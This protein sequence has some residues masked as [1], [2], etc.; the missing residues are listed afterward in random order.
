MIKVM[1]S[2]ADDRYDITVVETAA[3]ALDLNGREPFDLYVLDISLPGMDGLSLCRR[4]RDGGSTKPIIF[5][6]AMVQY[7]V[8]TARAL[9]PNGSSID[10]S[11]LSSRLPSSDADSR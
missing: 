8:V 7:S 10:A 3:E 2:R 5:F 4:L 6:S 9:M 1:L 11:H